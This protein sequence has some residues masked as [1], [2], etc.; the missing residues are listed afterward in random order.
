M[1]D[2]KPLIIKLKGNEK[3]VRL[4][5]GPAGSG[6]GKPQTRG[7]RSGYVNLKPNQDVGEHN[8][9]NKEEIILILSGKA[10]IY[11]DKYPP[12]SASSDSVIYIPPNTKHNVKNTGRGILRYIYIVNPT[13]HKQE[14][15]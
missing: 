4:L 15:V 5:S 2:I 3:Y 9:E 13:Q 1:A 14:T 6:T 10:E 11:C 8:T 7:L 12:I